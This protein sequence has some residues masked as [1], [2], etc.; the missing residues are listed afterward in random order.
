[1]SS[2]R[3]VIKGHG[4]IRPSDVKVTTEY[5]NSDVRFYFP[6]TAPIS[7]DDKEVTLECHPSGMKLEQKF[8]VKEM[9]YQNKLAL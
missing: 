9:R 2:T 4:E 8:H 1:M 7:L 3:L 6:K 5:S